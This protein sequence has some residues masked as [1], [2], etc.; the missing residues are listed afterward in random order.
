MQIIPN[1]AGA[2]TGRIIQNDSSKR[3]PCVFVDALKPIFTRLT[4]EDILQR[5]LKGFTQNQ[6]ESLN[7]TVWNLVPRHVSVANDVY[8][9]LWVKQFDSLMLEVFQ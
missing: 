4:N 3:L 1:M 8:K 7:G 9:L 2:S 5:C 6:N